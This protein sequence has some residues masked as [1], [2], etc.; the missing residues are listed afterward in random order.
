[1]KWYKNLK[2]RSK[3]L[4]AFMLALAIAVGSNVFTL[5]QFRNTDAAYSHGIDLT[6]EQ[7]DH[8]FD[9]KDNFARVR[10]IIREIYYPDNVPATL[11][12]LRTELDTSLAAAIDE[13]NVL[14]DVVP[15]NLKKEIDEILPGLVRYRTDAAAVIE[16]LIS[17]GYVDINDENYRHALI[18]AQT[19]T[20][21]MTSEYAGTLTNDISK[22]SELLLTELQRLDNELSN[23][24]VQTQTMIIVVL[25]LMAVVI[26]VMA[27]Y[28]P[29]LISIPLTA[30]STFME[31]AGTTGN[32]VLRAEDVEVIRVFAQAKDEIGRCIGSSAAF[33]ERIN[34]IA[35]VLDK[36]AHGDLTVKVNILSQEDV[37]G[38]SLNYM[39]NNMNKMFGQITVASSEVTMGASQIAGSSQTLAAGSTEQASSVE[40]LSASI[41]EITEKTKTNAEMAG[42]A[43]DMS[44]TITKNAERGN[45]QMLNLVSSVNEINDA[46]QLIKNIIKTIDD[47]AFQTNILAL[48]AAVEAA[49]AGQHGK[50]FAVVAEEV[51]NLAAKSAESAKSTAEMIENSIRKS[52]D[53]LA[54][55]SETAE[56]LAEIVKGIRQNTEIV[57]Q[58]SLLSNEQTEAISQINIGIEQ[59]SSVIQQNSATA[60]E[61]AASAEEMN[62]QAVTMQDIVGRFKLK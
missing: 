18:L 44:Q 47:I 15:D 22:L 20:N 39:V 32:I 21:R 43:S 4:A 29:S 62:S 60:Q 36:V 6:Q 13:L 25:V 28:I 57:K 17:V 9:V 31:K 7:F 49:R 10:M 59:V 34:E 33:V 1:M 56:S 41:T 19:E 52:N 16:S 12:S 35:A 50:G 30:L 55:A 23:S 42:K 24:T 5:I 37:I 8:V 2:V 40:E 45:E 14:R 53:G 46:S 3:L 54:I 51:R 26:L 48:N 11:I 61:S 27:L 58:I 38:N